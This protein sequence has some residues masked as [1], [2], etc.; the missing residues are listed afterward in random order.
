MSLKANLFR[1]NVFLKDK[2][3]KSF[4]VMIKEVVELWIIK[5]NFPIHYFGRFLYRKN[6][7]NYKDF[8]DMKEYASIILSKENNQEEFVPFLNNKLVFAN[9]CEKHDLPTPKVISYNL[10]NQFF[11]KGE[12]RRIDNKK[13]LIEYFLMI[14]KANQQE[15][16]FVKSLIGYGGRGVHLLKLKN[17]KEQVEEKGDLLLSGSFIHQEFII[18]HPEVN[19]IYPSSV[20]TLRIETYIDNVGDTHILGTFMRFGTG[21]KVVDNVG[22][23]GFFVPINAETGKLIEKG[24]HGMILGGG[25]HYKHPDTG[26]VFKGFNVPFFEES[27]ELCKKLSVYI[28][29]KL[30]GWDIALTPDGPVIVEGNNTPGITAG[31]V[32]YGGYVKHPLYKQM[33]ANV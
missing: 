1:I 2:N 22:S 15:T 21:G 8:L 33:I 4:F 17:L 24:T 5:K 12:I 31:E 29:L 27:K 9:F 26:F 23:G 10:K 20:N 16:L 32:A 18:Q 6:A 25:E 19:E 30:A 13:K 7:A 14:F 3:K 28:P 11:Y